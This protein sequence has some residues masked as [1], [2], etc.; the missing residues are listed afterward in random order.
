MKSL[1]ERV[2]KII[3]VVELIVYYLQIQNHIMAHCW[4]QK[5][6]ELL[7]RCLGD[8]PEELSKEF[9][10][11]LEMMMEAIDEQDEIRLADIYEEG[12]LPLLYQVQEIV[13]ES[14]DDILV[15][16]WKVN[17]RVLKDRFPDLYHKILICRENVPD[18][19]KVSWARTGDLVLDIKTNQT[20]VRVASGIDPWKEGLYYSESV[21]GEEEYLMIGFGLG[22]HVEFLSYQPQCRKIV[23]LE[24]DLNQLAIALSYRNLTHLLQ[25]RN[26]TLVY[27][28][29]SQEYLKY[30]K[31]LTEKTKVCFWCPSIR[32]ISDLC[33]REAL[34]DYRLQLFSIES[35][36]HELQKNFDANL[37][38][39][40]AEVFSL[41][42]EFQK[43][44]ILF[45]A[46]GPSLDENLALIKRCDLSKY[47]VVCV[48]KVASKLISE[49][50]EVNYIV[51]TDGLANT[52][53]QINDIEE[54][55][56]PLI[57]LSTAALDV[58]NDYKGKRYIAFQKGYPAAEKY[59]V[60]NH[61]KLFETGG[62][63]A[64]FALDLLIHF[65]CSRVVCIG[66]DMAF[67]EEKTHA[68]N[69]GEKVV[70]TENLRQVEGISSEYVYTSKT[71]DIYRKWIERRIV[72]VRN[73]ELIN[74]SKG[75][76]IHGMKEVDLKDVLYS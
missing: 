48:G 17:R 28:S 30:F 41:K 66:L 4:I 53:W 8:I 39:Q 45:I 73:V 54:C 65:E 59:A 3:H 36:E 25:N 29:E 5:V 72:D 35:M 68:G 46:A 70:N 76:R 1:F 69:L 61:Y 75:A 38:K 56:V 21:A 43:K 12:L 47:T 15:D 57:Y 11:I 10:P 58:V 63:V 67:S 26:I 6:S 37:D 52:R 20:I 55:G 74:A 60:D 19:Y 9:L 23:V 71:L 14:S 22:Y 27:C 7:E 34:E 32:C 40:D 2:K 49:G 62:S 16:Y 64:T 44:E 42:K 33:L 50:I 24:N 31:D 51:V 13:F 18:Q